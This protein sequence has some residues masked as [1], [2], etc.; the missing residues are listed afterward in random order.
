MQ[1]TGKRSFTRNPGRKKHLGDL[2]SPH[3]QPAG[4]F[5]LI[6]YFQDQNKNV[7]DESTVVSKSGG[8]DVPKRTTLPSGY[9]LSKKKN[10]KGLK[11]L[12]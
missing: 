8:K 4:S 7:Y 12:I 2:L 3:P 6:L 11:S 10:K 5:I 9:V 1:K